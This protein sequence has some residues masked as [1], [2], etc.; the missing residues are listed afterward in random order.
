MRKTLENSFLSSH[1]SVIHF[2]SLCHRTHRHQVAQCYPKET[3][4]FP[5]ELATLLSENYASLS[6]DLRRSFVQNLVMLRNKDVITSIEYVF[7]FKMKKSSLI[8]NH[9]LLKT[10]FPL[11]SRTTSGTLRSFIRKTI[12]TDIKTANSR[13]KNHKVNRAVQAMLFGM[14]ERG[15]DAEVQGDKGKLRDGRN[16]P[17]QPSA[18]GVEALWAVILTKELWKKGIWSVPFLELLFVV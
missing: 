3:A 17:S 4:E 10:L 18:N 13:T 16:Q 11:L 12:L 6:P 9:S 5:N 2:L 14:I 8:A 7:Y 15:M 1:R